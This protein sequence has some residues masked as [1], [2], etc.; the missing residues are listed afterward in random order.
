M[1]YLSVV[2]NHLSYAMLFILL[3]Q[4][5]PQKDKKKKKLNAETPERAPTPLLGRLV[6]CSAHG[7]SFVRD[8]IIMAM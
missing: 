1:V 6:W 2:N 8:N 5:P 3:S 7:C 4:P